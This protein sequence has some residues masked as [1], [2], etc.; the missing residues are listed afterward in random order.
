MK[1]RNTTRMGCEECIYFS[2]RNNCIKTAYSKEEINKGRTFFTLQK[3]SKKRNEKGE[4]ITLLSGGKTL[5]FN[6][7]ES[8]PMKFSYKQEK[9]R[10]KW[11]ERNS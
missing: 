10:L 5:N 2:K 3:K 7:V 4:E 6:D 9:Q 1:K 8:C 11:L